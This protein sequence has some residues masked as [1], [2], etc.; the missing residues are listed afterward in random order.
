MRRVAESG[1]FFVAK[2]RIRPAAGPLPARNYESGSN[3][4]ACLI[5]N[6]PN[7]GKYVVWQK[8]IMVGAGR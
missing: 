8:E 3:P 7:R 2:S 6:S 4:L 1:D 5:D